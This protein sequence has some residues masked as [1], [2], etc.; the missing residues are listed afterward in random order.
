MLGE[1]LKR[2]FVF[3]DNA[4]GWILMKSGLKPGQRPEILNITAPEL[5]ESL[6]RKTVDAGSDI[7]CTNTFGANAKVLKDTGYSVGEII[8]RLSPLRKKRRLAKP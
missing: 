5:V 2:D 4:Y 6:Q 8:T 3:F 7:V 1:L